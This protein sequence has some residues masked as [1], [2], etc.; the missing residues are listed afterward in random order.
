MG[1]QELEG[2]KTGID[3]HERIELE[4]AIG[5]LGAQIRFG[6]GRESM[7]LSGNCLKRNFPQ[8]IS[9]VEEMLLEPRWDEK[10]FEVVRER[11]LDNIRQRATEP[12]AIASDLFY[13]ALYTGSDSLLANNA[14]G[15]EE[16]ISAITL[17][18]LKQFYVQ[19][20]K[21]QQARMSFVGGMDKKQTVHALAN[22][23]KHW[24]TSDQSAEAAGTA[25]SATTTENVS[26]S[27]EDR[28]PQIYFADYP[29]ARQSFI[30]I[31]SKAMS[32]ADPVREERTTTM[33]FL[34]AS[35][36]AFPIAGFRTPS[37]L[38]STTIPL[39]PF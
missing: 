3:A 26:A 35:F 23:T 32:A 29:G 10:S 1:F 31:G 30:I 34:I 15:T 16:S 38:Q 2:M 28:G 27:A 21:P 13:K 24:K 11:A 4:E 39:T 37:P 33:P 22:L 5:Q 14:L 12:Q 6:S 20:I 18:D 19:N 17:D 8:V 25:P 9:L 36:K 7:T